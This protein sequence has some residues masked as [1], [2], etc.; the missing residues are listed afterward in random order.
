MRLFVVGN[1]SSGKSYFIDKIKPLLPNYHILK[2]D[3]YRK[4]YCDGSLEKEIQ[5]WIDFPNEIIKHNNVIV[6]LL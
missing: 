2:I 1:I 5:M 6:E 3:E 4:S